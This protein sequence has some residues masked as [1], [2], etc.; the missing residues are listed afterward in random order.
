MAARGQLANRTGSI[1]DA[2]ESD[3]VESLRALCL[4][5]GADIVKRYNTQGVSVVQQCCLWSAKKC[6]QLVLGL[7]A[8]V[9]AVDSVYLGLTPLMVAAKG[10]DIEVC[11]L[12]VGHGA[13]VRAVD[14]HGD[15]CLH[16]AVRTGNGKLVQEVMREAESV[17]RGSTKGLLEVKNVKGS[18]CEDLAKSD[19]MRA[20]LQ[21]IRRGER[22][23]EL[24]RRT[25]LKKLKVGVAKIKAARFKPKAKPKGKSKTKPARKP[26]KAER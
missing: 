9:D 3:D 5:Q 1:F 15:T 16:H 17:K 26:P 8:N 20:V 10:E 11:R 13:D 24:K 21:R 23:R 4:L 22:E 12:L 18:S 7:G 2:V 6:L 19:T 14:V 25:N